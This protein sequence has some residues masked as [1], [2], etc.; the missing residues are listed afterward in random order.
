MSHQTQRWLQLVAE[1]AARKSWDSARHKCFVSYHAADAV[2]VAAFLEAYGSEFIAKTVGVTDEDDF[3]NSDDPDYIMD[4]IRS[5]YLGDS[6]VT[7]LLVGRCTWARR[8]V[9]WEL[10]SSLRASRHSSVNGLLAIELPSAAATSTLP[11]R[12]AD[13]VIR[14]AD[15]LDVGYGRYVAYPSSADLLRGQIHDAYLARTQR[16]HLLVNNRARR[17]RSSSCS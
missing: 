14:D 16:A 5:R 4:Q 8:Y 10:Y 13:N 7:L 6:T 15:G 11:A 2:E 9:D 17:V 3:I 12:A 1:S